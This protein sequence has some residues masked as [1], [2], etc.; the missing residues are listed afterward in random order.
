VTSNDGTYEVRWKNRSGEIE[1][2]QAFELEVNVR[3]ADG[4]ELEESLAFDARMPEHG[5]GMNREAA[6][7]ALGGGRFE[8]AGVFLHMPG[9]WELYFDLTRG[10]LTE[11]AQASLDLD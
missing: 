6:V 7:K 3:R 5:H 1:L 4:G 10:A 8:V 2:G 11:R 9:Y